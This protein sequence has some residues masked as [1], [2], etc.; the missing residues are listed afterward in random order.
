MRI[1]HIISKIEQLLALSKSITD[2]YNNLVRIGLT[3]ITNQRIHNR[4]SDLKDDWNQFSLIHDA[5]SIS[6]PELLIEEQ[7]EVHNHS[8]F[9]ENVY[10]ATKEGYLEALGKFIFLLD[11]EQTSVNGSSSSQT[12]SLPSTS[13]NFFP[14]TKLPQIVIPPFNGEPEK[15]LPFKG[16]FVSVVIDNSH[17]PDIEKLQYLKTLLKGS[18]F[19]LIQ[20][21]A[22]TAD[23]F[24]KTWDS[25]T[26][27]YENTRL[28]VN[29]TLQ[30][31]MNLK[32]MTK[33]SAKEIE[34]LY[35]NIT[36]LYRT[37][38]TLERERPVSTWDDFLVFICSQ[39]L[40][41]ET[42]KL[43]ESKLGS[44]KTPPLWTQFKDFLFERMST[45][46]SYERSQNVKILQPTK[47][48]T[49]KVNHQ[50][51]SNNTSSK[52]QP[53]CV[54][55]KGKHYV[56][57]CPQYNPKTVEQKLA[58]VKKHKLCFNCLGAHRVS[59]C[60]V[61]KRCQKCGSKH[62]T[63]IHQAN[64][65]KTKDKEN[66]V[67]N[68][69]SSSNPQNSE[70]KVLHSSNNKSVG[71]SILLATAQVVI[72]SSTGQTM[73]A[74]AL[75]DQGSEVSIITE[76]VTQILKLTRSH[77]FTSLT[78]I[79]A[80]KSQKT[81]G[82]V[83]F[84]IKSHFKSDFELT[85][86]AYILPK[87]TSSLPSI[88][89]DK[90]KWNHLQGLELADP[91][92]FKPGSIDLILGADRYGQIIEEGIIRGEID[93]PIAQLTKLGWIVSGVTNHAKSGNLVEGYHVTVDNEIFDL[94]KRFWE[95]EEI[96]TCKKSLSVDEQDCE[97]HFVATHSRDANGR[98]VV[99]L[100]FKESTEKL[101]NSKSKAIRLATNLFNRLSNNPNYA[102]LYSGFI[103]EYEDLNHMQRIPNNQ[104]EPQRV[105]YLPHHG[106]YR[107]QSLS[108]KLRVGFNASSKT[109]SG[110]SLNQLL[111]SGA[112]L[113]SNLF[114][115]L[116]WFR[117]F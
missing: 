13:T 59:T 116:I 115:V 14:H 41:S 30:S 49:A 93:T 96:V 92:F 2:S 39:K 107:E 113:Q 40:D 74:R 46:Q 38:E 106:V 105:Y 15:W 81:K 35:S 117:L 44:S 10:N 37:F 61:T 98:Y 73:K 60:R 99:K 17:I 55:C 97:N 1:E 112:K 89:H 22:L 114:N 65:S 19:Q 68:E 110:Y 9:D 109:A 78:G 42:A 45:L 4:L 91:T 64:Y 26:T 6:I 84:I 32:R 11:L 3:N 71:S 80:Q 76:R 87:L 5:I 43:W 79:G 75:I 103:Q 48:S 36:Q 104:N 18:A 66:S 51:N 27:F 25:L 90:D 23:N 85:V 101:G 72:V 102:K 100:P 34:F 47:Q 94:V 63:T 83:S 88:K 21:T 50:G 33:E 77:S 86:N 8:H 69:S 29:T 20:H 12:I 16:L 67:K 52:Y 31:L 28:H 54:V 70:S 62:H 53:F 57:A 111:H 108:T 82:L 58:I 24:K 95:V 7:V 56:A